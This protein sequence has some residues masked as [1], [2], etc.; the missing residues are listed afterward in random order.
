MESQS[1]IFTCDLYLL[2]PPKVPFAICCERKMRK[3]LMS[4]ARSETRSCYL[5]NR[6]K[7]NFNPKLLHFVLWGSYSKNISAGESPNTIFL[8]NIREKCFYR[9]A[10]WT[11]RDKAWGVW[12]NCMPQECSDFFRHSLFTFTCLFNETEFSLPVNCVNVL[13][14]AYMPRHFDR[15][16]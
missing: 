11:T 9:N 1:I 10:F 7:I 8:S 12:E 15:R 13:F 4:V 5:K 6:L 14:P 2:A 3:A 16:F